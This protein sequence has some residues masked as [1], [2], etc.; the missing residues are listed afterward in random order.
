METNTRRPQ[1]LVALI[2]FVLAIAVFPF[3][4]GYVDNPDTFQY[5]SVA[6]KLSEGNG[7]VNGY[8]SPLISWLLVLPIRF[9]MDGVIAFKLVQVFIGWWAISAWYSLVRKYSETNRLMVLYFPLPFVLVYGL[10]NLTPDLLF[11]AICL[12]LIVEVLRDD[13]EKNFYKIGFLGALLFFAKAFGFPFFIIWLTLA[14]FFITYSFKEYLHAILTFFV[15]ILPWVILISIHYHQPTISL[16][17]DFNRSVDVAP[18]P[19]RGTELPI[20]KGGLYQPQPY[21]LS[22]WEDPGDFV[23]REQV[24]LTTSPQH[25]WEVV[26]RNAKSIWYFD[27]KRQ[28]G[29]IFLILLVR[30]LLFNRRIFTRPEIQIGVL[31][32]L[33]VY[34]GYSMIL[35]HT[36]YV[37]INTWLMFFIGA[38]IIQRFVS[39]P[40]FLRTLLLAALLLFSWKRPIKQ[41]LFV[42]DKSIPAQWIFKG[43]K[44]PFETMQ[45]MYQTDATFVKTLDQMKALKLDGNLVA[46]KSSRGER[47][48]Y[49]KGLR[50]AYEN[51]LTFIGTVPEFN[52]SLFTKFNIRYVMTE[53]MEVLNGEKLVDDGAIQLYE[54]KNGVE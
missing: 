6:R 4:V 38:I 37:W 24:R 45:V 10:L 40:Q 13:S 51:H 35:V 41:L 33:L 39:A 7:V 19:G 53:K 54:I 11:V 21:S 49:T 15:L 52:D 26:K 17:G 43:L 9:G 12:S 14:G 42:E 50:V 34:G 44:R 20:L 48:L 23:S 29:F 25:F 36:R 1:F 30:T 32:I 46:I 3:L 22:A 28:L 5:L 2:Y 27:F 8:W 47:D 31:T 18:L 16:A